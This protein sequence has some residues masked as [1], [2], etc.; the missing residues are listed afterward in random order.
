MAPTLLGHPDRQEA[1]E[2]LSWECNQA[3]QQA[4]RMGRWKAVRSGGTK[5]PIELYNLST[6][7]GWS[8]NIAADH[9]AVVERMRRIMAQA[10]EGSEYTKCWPLPEYRRND[11]KWDTWIF[12][13]LENGSH[14]TA[15]SD[16]DT[17]ISRMEP[18]GE[19][20]AKGPRPS[21][22]ARSPLLGP[23]FAGWIGRGSG[24]HD[25]RRSPI[26]R[27]VQT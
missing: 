27:T 2:C 6:N 26:P 16:G 13:Q 12:D 9:P 1:H 4:A 15:C 7:I 23:G 22:D 3:S 5:E 11:I 10:R 18:G 17:H 24:S 21:L 8:T 25:T 14:S 19:A 20:M